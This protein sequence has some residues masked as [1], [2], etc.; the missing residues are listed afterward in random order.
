[1]AS[2]AGRRGLRP[3]LLGALAGLLEG[4]WGAPFTGGLF[5]GRVGW[6]EAFFAGLGWLTAGMAGGGP[7]LALWIGQGVLALWARGGGWR[8]GAGL[9]LFLGGFLFPGFVSAPLGVVLAGVLSGGWRYAALALA[10]AGVYGW[11]GLLLP[12]GTWAAERVGLE[13][14]GRFQGM[15]VPALVYGGVLLLRNML[16]GVRG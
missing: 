1:M 15:G 12:L 4:P 11:T 5:A 3:E 2:T 6:R 14:G 9:A 10:G 16:L 8:L 13:R 7:L